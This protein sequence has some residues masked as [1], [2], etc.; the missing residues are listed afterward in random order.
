MEGRNDSYVAISHSK[1]FP[2]LDIVLVLDGDRR[3]IASGSIDLGP[4]LGAGHI[5]AGSIDLGSSN[6]AAHVSA[7]GVD[8]LSNRGRHV[9]GLLSLL[10]ANRRKSLRRS[11]SRNFEDISGLELSFSGVDGLRD[12]QPVL[13]LLLR[14][15][16][17]LDSLVL[18]LST[19][20]GG[21]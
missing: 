2:S 21:V 4:G 15:E 9:A 1:F 3:Q 14:V 7:L 11:R 20:E 18:I 16:N 17:F 5:A 6:G 12:G 10:D 19:V 13:Q 8:F